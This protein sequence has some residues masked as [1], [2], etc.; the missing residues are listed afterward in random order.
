M[1]YFDL[2]A[3][4]FLLSLSLCLD[5]GIVNVA[6]INT[7]IRS[8]MRAAMLLG[9]GSCV[10][11]LIYA[12]LS[13]MGIGLLLKFDGV[14]WFISV[15]GVALLLLLAW[16]AARS[17]WRDAPGVLAAETLPQIAPSHLFAR[18]LLLSLA[19]P[20]SIL[21]FAAVGG[22]VIARSNPQSG[23]GLLALFGGF[24]CGGFSWCLFI[25][26]VSARGGR[27]LGDRFRRYCAALSAALFIYF[28]VR[29]L[30]NL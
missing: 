13:L 1:I 15:G 6:L 8:G 4:G 7:A 24:F 29:I 2:F 16:G 20:T 17:V 12:V 10:G 5:I 14:R 22:N 25:T 19:S 21:W 23:V 3:S 30:L 27:L 26:G 11:D 28:A 18:G 9:L